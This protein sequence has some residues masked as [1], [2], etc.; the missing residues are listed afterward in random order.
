MNAMNGLTHTEIVHLKRQLEKDNVRMERKVHDG[1]SHGAVGGHDEVVQYRETTDD[2][3]IA[4]V[5]NDAAISTIQRETTSL[6][7]IENSLQ[8]ISGGSYGACVDCGRHIGL[9]RL[10]ANPTATRCINCQTKRERYAVRAS[11]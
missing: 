4:D 5:L 6:A 9:K 3:A 11:L 10:T 2:D 8:A 7:A 1:F